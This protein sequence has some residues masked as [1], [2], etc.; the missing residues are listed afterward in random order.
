MQKKI[1]FIIIISAIIATW[2]LTGMDE[3]FT[4]AKIKE[5]Q[6][7]LQNLVHL[8]PIKMS[9]AYFFAYV[10]LASLAIPGMPLMTLLGASIFGFWWCLLL[11]SF[12]STIGASF[13]FLASRYLFRD[14][15]ENKFST[16]CSKVN[17]G[18]KRD[19]IF[20]LFSLRMIPVV[21]FSLINVSMGLTQIKVTTFYWVSQLGMLVGTMIFINAG[22]QIGKISNI[23][24]IFSINIMLSLALL[25]VFPWVV[26]FILKRVKKHFNSK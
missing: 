2:F 22:T 6:Q 25:G 5:Q 16:V 11:D 20:Y 4:L 26:K 24:D 21:P 1:I 7:F 17:H 15:V 3:Y 8:Y 18:L 14:F 9:I 10:L 12:A 19:G 23:E 13:A